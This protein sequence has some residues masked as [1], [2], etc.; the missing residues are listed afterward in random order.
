MR[1]APWLGV[2]IGPDFYTHFGH[3]PISPFLPQ[4]TQQCTWPTYENKKIISP[5]IKILKQKKIAYKNK[6]TNE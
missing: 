5:K 6:N 1:W 3:M 2:A 4:E